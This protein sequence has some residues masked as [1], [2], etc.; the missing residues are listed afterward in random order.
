VSAPSVLEMVR[1]LR[2]LGLVDPDQLKLT[3]EGTS[4]ALLFSSRRHAA[5]LL[6]QDVLGLACAGVSPEAERLAPNLSSSLTR[7]LLAGRPHSD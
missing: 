6:T 3:D 1:R 2:R 7:R 5:H 4:A